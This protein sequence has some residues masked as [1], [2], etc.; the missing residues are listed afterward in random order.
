MR[1]S[2]IVLVWTLSFATI[3]L[4]ATLHVPGD[5][6]TI[7]SAID[8]A[9][10][11]DTVLVAPGTYVENIDFLGKA[12]TVKSDEG[13]EATVIDGNEAGSVVVFNKS[14]TADSVLEGFTITN[15]TGFG[16][17]WPYYGG[18]IYC[19]A[20][21]TIKGNIITKNVVPDPWSQ[22]GGIYFS[23]FGNS[24]S[25]HDNTISENQAPWGGGIYCSSESAVLS[26]N[27]VT[28][29]ISTYGE[30]GGIYLEESFCEALL[31]QNYILLNNGG[32]GAGIYC[33][34]A[35]P[36]ITENY[37]M[38]N[39]GTSGAGLWIGT[40]VAS[41]ADNTFTGNNGYKAAGIY[42]NGCGSDVVIEN[43]L[44]TN[45]L[46][47][48]IHCY[49]GS[50]TI[51]NNT[52]TGNQGGGIE[53]WDESNS[54]VEGNYFR[55]NTGSSGVGILCWSATPLITGNTFYSNWADSD[56]GAISCDT[57]SE[58]IIKN[59]RFLENAA[60]F[61]GGAIDCFYCSS[62]IEDNIF[63][64]NH[65]GFGG[66]IHCAE[67]SG[68]ISDNFISLNGANYGG[69]IYISGYFEK[70]L[71]T[72]NLLSKNWANKQGGGFFIGVQDQFLS[73]N[74][75]VG[76]GALDEGGGIYSAG[77]YVTNVSNTILW[78]NSATT[79][80][81]I[82]VAFNFYAAE[83]NIS[84][85]D[86]K[87]G[88]AS[89]YVAPG[90][91]LNWGP[92]MIN[93]YPLFVDEA[94]EDYHLLYTSPCRNSGD[95]SVPG[96]PA[97]DFENDPRIADGTVDMGADE[98]YT[99]LY[100]TGDAAPGGAI[101]GKLVGL[102]GSSPM[103]LF[104]GFGVLDPPLPTIWGSFYLESPWILIT[105]PTMPGSGVLQLPTTLPL[106]PAAPYDVPMQALIGNIL[107]NLSVLEVRE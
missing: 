97:E 79:G 22:G 91:T 56:G 17:Y 70:P 41:V 86:V 29:N 54:V 7:Q 28:L 11:G 94:N 74:T 10:G 35:R 87:G 78:N 26:N 106:T 72:N 63:I 55:D 50:P 98:F 36:T 61:S 96:L 62:T 82:Y 33:Y 49:S 53:F 46:G 9:V 84:Y 51:M 34:W 66:A 37:I 21:P 45:N 83:L 25:L 99:H 43:N 15:G 69:G 18:G 44:F 103:G 8:A 13:P 14:E 19:R 107:S 89:V 24:P 57:D 48:V 20:S 12:I 5:Y 95:N 64:D 104:L 16:D 47:R 23:G 80:P 73:N 1:P 58:A 2:I 67:Y 100:Y 92:G 93:A 38:G 68:S 42:V 30:G 105:L 60:V 39:E 40:D 77:D 6:P 65:S 88:Q 3:A 71:V 31:T 85:S 52:F 81:E 76:N 101:T 32:S 90:N 27:T 59:N 75:V 102:P 4:P